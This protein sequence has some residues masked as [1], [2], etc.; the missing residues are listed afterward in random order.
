MSKVDECG[1]PLMPNWERSRTI[2]Y[3]AHLL[4]VQ[5]AFLQADRSPQQAL[6]LVL[7]TV[8]QVTSATLGWL[9]IEEV[10]VAYSKTVRFSEAHHTYGKSLLG[11]GLV[12]MIPL[13]KLPDV[14]D[15]PI[16][17]LWAMPFSDKPNGMFCLGYGSEPGLTDEDENFLQL[18]AGMVV[19]YWRQM[20][21]F[22]PSP[23]PDILLQNI[24]DGIIWA[25]DQDIILVFNPTAAA[26]FGI[27]AE[28]AIGRPLTEVIRDE[29][30]LRIIRGT[31]DKKAHRYFIEH[32]GFVYQPILRRL[33][34][35]H[36]G[37]LLVLADV[38]YF[39]RLNENMDVFLQT[40]SHDLRSPLT[41]A[42]GF[43]D[44]LAMVGSLNDKQIE[45]REKILTSIGDMTDLVEKVLD[46]GRLDPEM[47]GYQ[48]RREVC[49]P[50]AVA[51]KV[52]ST[53]SAAA[54]KKGLMLSLQV[55]LGIPMMNL[56][57]MMI[58]RALVNLVENAIK[59]TPQGGSIEVRVYIENNQLMLEVHDDGLGI[60]ADKLGSIFE[61]GSRVRR[62]EHRAIRG[63]GLGLYI[64]KNIAE[65]HGG[66][67]H[68]ESVEG[69]GSRFKIIIPIAGSNVV[70]GGN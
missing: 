12:G 23:I 8:C 35:E 4:E 22:T 24:R 2:S 70:G 27:A 44:M 69:E 58:E 30:L 49:D 56:D 26:I 25:D 54:T 14:P 11:Q 55:I 3:Q 13:D 43:V 51:E 61:R 45:M 53:L 65:Q 5:Q 38:S 59:Y 50:V 41:A 63:S 68:V 19:L 67:A 60:P 7:E 32:D 9:A 39:K 28:E 31:Q 17:H 20:I 10:F 29:G 64:V 47:G 1:L 52:V 62:P 21:S 6:S 57:Q 66:T 18:V 37:L 33:E 36:N 48:L 15:L 34:G 42:K 46:A 16:T 40:V